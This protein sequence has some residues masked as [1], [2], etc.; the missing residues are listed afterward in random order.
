M[1]LEALTFDQ[2]YEIFRTEFNARLGV[3]FAFAPFSEEDAMAGGVGVITEQLQQY[4]EDTFRRVWIGG[5]SGQELDVLA[6][7]RWR[8]IRIPASRARGELVLSR[9][10]ATPGAET[11]ST[12]DEFQ[13]A[14]D[15]EGNVKRVRATDDFVMTGTALTIT[16]ESTVTD[17]DGN[18]ALGTFD[19]SAGSEKVVPFVDTTITFSQPDA[20][21]GGAPEETDEEF[22]ERIRNFIRNRQRATV[23]AVSFAALSVGGVA[24]A[25]LTEDL[26]NSPG[27]F[28]MFIADPDGRTSQP[29][30]DLVFTTLNSWRA[31]GV[32]AN[33]VGAT[34]KSVN[35][36]NPILV[37]FTF[38]D[39]VTNE[40][41]LVDRA[42]RLMLEYTNTLAAGETWYKNMCEGAGRNAD[43]AK[44]NNVLI[45]DP[46]V[47]SVGATATQIIHEELGNFRKV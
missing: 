31:A 15:S 27:I 36:G 32:G 22:R 38:E 10:S 12:G 26:V 5:A 42:F 19:S 23:E 43:T 44:I 46:S 47:S 40:D 24:S 35:A 45:A 4:I 18:S 3:D 25:A 20:I 9:P 8:L 1:A 28:N 34:F 14:P 2:S 30:I 41:V 6:L 17:R 37:Q 16:V 21:A 7:D 13:T 11:I 29:L 39:N 33:V